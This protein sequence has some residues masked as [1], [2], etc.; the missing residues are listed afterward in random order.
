MLHVI[1]TRMMRLAMIASIRR[2]VEPRERCA[3]NLPGSAL[4][5]PE[6]RKRAQPLRSQAGNPY[7]AIRSV[8][9]FDYV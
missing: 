1:I 6:K 7:I 9:A 5:W 3:A 2:M 8:F 4:G